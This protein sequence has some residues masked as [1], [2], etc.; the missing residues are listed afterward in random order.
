MLLQA[1]VA[2][3]AR[4]KV[5][6]VLTGQGAD[7]PLGGY[8][9][10]QA[11]RILPLLAGLLGGIAGSRLFDGIARRREVVA[12]VRRVLSSPPG[13]DRTAALFSPLTP[14]E[15]AGL[16]RGSRTSDARDVVVSGIQGWWKRADGLDDIAKVLYIDAR[17][18]LA[19]DLLLVA[20][21]MAMARSLEAR[22]P[23][24]DLDYLAAVEAIPGKQ[25][26]RFFGG[27]KRVQR[28]TARLLLPRRLWDRIRA[29]T[30]TLSPKR[31]FE[32]PVSSWF[33][34][35]MR[36]QL[37]RELT[38]PASA[39]LDYLNAEPVE[40]LVASFLDGAGRS[41][42][43]VLALYALSSW[44]RGNLKGAPLLPGLAA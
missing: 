17:T 31:G 44:L 23:F 13:L 41:Y 24:L 35:P 39:L 11:A 33:R 26:V 19:D 34:G 37:A 43:M 32:V 16:V 2:A 14:E 27:R 9:R 25:R 40:R 29:S 21:K 20:D 36:A 3:L 6:V 10:H 4:N 12:R 42:R 18:S 38:G 15:A 7:E 5:K 28:E 30:G 1:D 8:P 22:V